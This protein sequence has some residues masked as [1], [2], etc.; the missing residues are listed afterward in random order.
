MFFIQHGHGKADKLERLSSK[1]GVSGVIL[2]PANEDLTSLAATAD[3]SRRH[4]LTVLADPQSYIYTPD[5]RGAARHHPDH[6]LEFLNMHWS[7]SAEELIDQLERV[8]LMNRNLGH[9]GPI[10]APGPYQATLA[11][12]WFG[13]ALQYARSSS[14]AFGQPNTLATIALDETQL[15]SWEDLQEW[16]DLLTT[17]PVRGF[18]LLV[19]RNRPIYPFTPWTVDSL[20][21]LLRVIYTLS[22]LNDYELVWGYAD[23][24]GLLGLAVGAS[25]FASG[26]T[27]G[28]RY[29]S[30]AK[31]TETRTGGSAPV[32][33]VTLPR[34]WSPLRKNEAEELY[35]SELREQIFGPALRSEFSERTFDSWR[36]PEAQLQHLESL[37]GRGHRLTSIADTSGRLDLVEHS[38]SRALEL[39]AS[40]RKSRQLELD[41]RYRGK[42]DTYS[43]AI[44]EFRDE[45]S[46]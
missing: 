22:E 15:E 18:Y 27:Y 34:L 31:W 23:T 4:G 37:A 28:L 6:D 25:A 42:I 12:H 14:S 24:D 10:I 38:L 44:R 39:F 17:L 1:R 40:I 41:P 43:R 32:A 13:P 16:L 45:E 21:N 11:G 3:L 29:F 30:I 8:R 20:R 9:V 26:W 2:S 19:N 5:P 7:Q 33:R 35:N 46:L 36:I